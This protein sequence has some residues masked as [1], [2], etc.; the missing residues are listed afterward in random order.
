MVSLDY[1]SLRARIY[2]VQARKYDVALILERLFFA[3][4]IAF[5]A[6]VFLFS[7]VLAASQLITLMQLFYVYAGISVVTLALAA[8]LYCARRDLPEE[9]NR[10]SRH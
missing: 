4:I 10:V 7:L 9:E 8:A 3:W 2:P 1:A 6:L 5:A